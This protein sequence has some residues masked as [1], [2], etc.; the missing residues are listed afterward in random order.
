MFI[1]EVPL[2]TTQISHKTWQDILIIDTRLYYDIT[3]SFKDKKY[4]SLK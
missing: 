3:L 1:F 4:Y 2:G